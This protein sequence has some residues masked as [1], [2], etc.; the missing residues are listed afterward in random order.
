[1][2]NLIATIS[3]HPI[4]TSII[5]ILTVIMYML[6]RKKRSV[7]EQEIQQKTDHLNKLNEQLEV[8][9]TNLVDSL[10]E[11]KDVNKQLEEKVNE[12]NDF[13]LVLTH[14]LISPLRNVEGMSNL[15][16][17]YIS[18]G[19]EKEEL[20]SLVD[21]IDSNVKKQLSYSK[22]LVKLAE[23]KSKHFPYSTIDTQ[24]LV[25][26]II[27]KHSF[28]IDQKH[29]E[30]EFHT[31]LPTIKGEKI[32]IQQIFHNLIDNSIKFTAKEQK[33]NKLTF[34][35]KKFR[36]SHH[37]AISD[38]GIGIPEDQIDH[39]FHAFRRAKTKE[40]AHIEGKGIGL[41]AVKSIVENYNGQIWLESTENIGTTAY[42]TL[43]EHVS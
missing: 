17:E 11:S 26:E 39:V 19:K 4:C 16:K 35:Y 24:A 7:L 14:D 34:M 23:L 10:M 1:M 9:N 29:I 43:P 28:D 38:T 32:R 15:L 21:R 25:E 18:E 31:D 20:Q 41:A 42:F 6:C 27:E 36:D 13:L 30:V 3:A 2:F 5:V 12:M 8:N 33:M 22:E 40:V 37:F